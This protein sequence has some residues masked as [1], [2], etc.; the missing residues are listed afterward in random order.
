MLKLFHCIF[1]FNILQS[2][3]SD[4]L[5]MIVFDPNDNFAQVLN[6]I[7]HVFNSGSWAS[8][9]NINEM[10]SLN[11][12]TQGIQLQKSQNW[13]TVF[14]HPH[15]HQR[16]CDKQAHGEPIT[17]KHFVIVTITIQSWRS[18]WNKSV[19]DF[20]KTLKY[21]QYSLILSSLL[22]MLQLKIKFS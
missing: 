21:L 14:G 4:F 1:H 2:L 15:D 17:I 8:T 9:F 16:L 5:V 13:I 11:C 6:C 7:F 22:S 20:W 18:D 12:M 3:L 10:C 19:S